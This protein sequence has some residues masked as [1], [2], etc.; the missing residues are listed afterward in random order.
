MAD[1]AAGAP[2]APDWVETREW[3]EALRDV[4]RTSGAARASRLLQSLQ[5]DAQRTGIPLPVTSRTPY[6]NTIPPEHQ[7]PYPG[8]LELERRITRL[9]RWN[10]IAMVTEANERTPGIGG[11]IST[12]A[13]AAVLYEVGFQ[14]FWRGP[15]APGGADLLYIQGHASPGI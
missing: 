12:Y 8:D 2:D 10:A 11:H 13:S 1:E 15:D 7:A 4:V 9:V 5:I 14:Q 6:V 3:T